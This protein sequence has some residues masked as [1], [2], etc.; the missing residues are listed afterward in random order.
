MG[1]VDED[2]ERVRAA[3]SIVEVV[4]PWSQ[5][6]RVGQRWV[7]LCPFHAEKTGSFNVNET[8][9]RYKCFGCGAGGDV[10]SFV[11]ETE[12]VDFVEAVE[13][14]AAKAGIQLRYTSGGE[15]RERQRRKG[16]VEA[17]A[18]AVAWYH[19]RLLTAPDAGPA[20]SYL[21]QRGID[22]EIV[23]RFN[24]GWAPAGWDELVKGAGIAAADLRDNGLAHLSSRQTLIDAFRARLLFPIFNEA[25]EPVALGG[26][27]LPGSTDPAKYKNSSETPIYSK[28]KTLYGLNWAKNDVVQHDQVI[29]CEGYT[30][31]IGFHQ[32]GVPRAVATCGTALTEE[33]VRLLT[34]FAKRVVLAFDA[35]AAGQA[36]A[37][38][39]Y[40][41][42]RKYEIAVSVLQLPSGRD[43]AEV[44]QSDPAALRA[45]VDDAL[46][47][48]GFR[49]HRVLRSGKITTPESRARLAEQ[50]MLIVNEHPNEN[51][52][53]IYAGEVASHCG[54]P[55]SDL[56][57]IARRGGTRVRVASPVSL[58]RQPRESAEIVALALLVH[59]WDDIAPLLIEPLFTDD[60]NV[61][62]FRT[63]G[64][65]NGDLDA[66]IAAADPDARE[67]L[68]RLA[69]ADP[70]ADP[71]TEARALI[72]SA[73]RREIEQIRRRGDLQAGR[74]LSDVKHQLELLEDPIAGS[75]AAD[76]LLSWLLR[77]NEES[78]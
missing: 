63:L 52:R 41:W 76:W 78:G 72:L 59:R 32:A 28:S 65:T 47:F 19:Q 50:A 20:R 25:G 64:D 24:L 21:R 70:D 4:T 38:R 35:D 60:V 26:R 66:A 13:K 77:R 57:A 18:K 53:K 7:G 44:A 8:N 67:L 46:P 3:V 16:L 33:H 1:I 74:E 36:A 23:R 68:E 17:M 55:V 71:A 30:D 42:E 31:V 39:F 49:L 10:I 29:V 62:V 27:I 2:I 5:L 15:G 69:V 51:V 9:G 58:V 12:H 37:D 11:R 34:R 6:K 75:A 40:E 61:M 73:S 48:L 56:V 43:P 45:A 14:L 54:L 22:G